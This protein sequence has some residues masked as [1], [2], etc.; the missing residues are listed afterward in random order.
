[1][2]DSVDNDKLE[3]LLQNAQSAYARCIDDQAGAGWPDFFDDDCL[4]V[5][6]TAENYRQGLEAGLIYADSKGMLKDRISA[7]HEANIYEAHCYRHILGQPVILKRE[8]ELV[9]SEC[10][11][12]VARIMRTGETT[13]FATGRYIDCY[14]I[15]N[16]Q[17]LIR[18]RKVVCDSNRIDTLLALPL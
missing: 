4:Y 1:M 12:V 13:L 10:S 17:P 15:K 5:V 2:S 3:R 6:T 16:N 7:L 9:W 11:F 8:G 18:E 14:R